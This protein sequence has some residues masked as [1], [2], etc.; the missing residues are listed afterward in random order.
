[1]SQ[2]DSGPLD[3]M[4]SAAVSRRM[5]DQFVGLAAARSRSLSDEIRCALYEH[6]RR[7]GRDL[8]DKPPAAVLAASRRVSA[9]VDAGVEPGVADLATLLV[10]LDERTSRYW[11]D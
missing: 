4:M 3:H 10:W 11:R 2:S 7:A 8:V 1:M 6:I 9:A 5:H